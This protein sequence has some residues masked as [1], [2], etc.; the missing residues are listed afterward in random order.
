MSSKGVKKPPVGQKTVLPRNATRV[1]TSIVVLV[2]VAFFFQFLK[3]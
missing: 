2:V 1:F 3:G